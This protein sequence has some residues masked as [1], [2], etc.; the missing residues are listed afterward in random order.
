MQKA[1][2]FNPVK[3]LLLGKTG[4]QAPTCPR[5]GE[6]ALGASPVSIGPHRCD[7]FCSY[8]WWKGK[9][10]GELSSRVLFSSFY[11]ISLPSLSSRHV[12]TAL[13]SCTGPLK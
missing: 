8:I 5:E 1:R 12:Q 9:T 13:F 3:Q 6:I 2:E 7:D 11:K 10:A 4:L